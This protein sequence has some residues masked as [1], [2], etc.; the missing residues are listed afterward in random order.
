[1][2]FKEKIVQNGF[3]TPLG[4]G[5]IASAILASLIGI[6]T[7]I[8]VFVKVF[9]IK[10]QFNKTQEER[11]A[12]AI[13]DIKGSELGT[14]DEFIN[15]AFSTNID[16]SDMLHIVKSVYLNYAKNVLLD[17]LNLENLYLT[18]K[19][20]TLANVEITHRA[21]NSKIWNEAALN[22]SDK[23]TEKPCFIAS[24]DKQYNLIVSANDNSSN[25]EIFNKLY[26]KLSFGGLLMV[27]QNPNIKS[28]LKDLKRDLKIRNI[29]FEA[30]KNKALFLYV[31]KSETEA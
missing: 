22:F 7:S 5:L 28:D 15:K 18:L 26:P 6:I 19:T 25:T 3:P 8:I 9:K 16:E 30:S 21:I 10:K 14:K 24:D 29:R 4:W 20:M 13:M 1:M 2:S 11:A 31:V 27:I 17:G 12:K 23:I